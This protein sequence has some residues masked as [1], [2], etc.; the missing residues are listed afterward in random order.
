[1]EKEYPSD[2]K[3]HSTR[4]CWLAYLLTLNLYMC[5]V[6]MC[7]LQT[8]YGF[9]SID[10]GILYPHVSICD[11]EIHNKQYVNVI[12][13]LVGYVG[14]EE[15]C[16]TSK[17]NT[18]SMTSRVER[19]YPSDGKSSGI[20]PDVYDNYS[21]A[22]VPYDL[23]YNHVYIPVECVYLLSNTM[24]DV[25]T[26]FVLLQVEV[27][28]LVTNRAGSGRWDDAATGRVQSVCMDAAN[29][30]YNVV[31]DRYDVSPLHVILSLPLPCIIPPLH[32]AE[33]LGYK[34][35]PYRHIVYMLLVIDRVLYFC[36]IQ[37]QCV[38]GFNLFKP[39]V[40][41]RAIT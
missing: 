22:A 33:S 28:P 30:S 24:H 31:Y 8:W 26:I 41:I 37:T 3:Q 7:I 21:S 12:L 32:V 4:S 6:S 2:C 19:E 15:S 25:Y 1:M 38:C 11:D 13:T 18:L 5:F 17:C 23:L 10:R 36:I 35:K 39:F 40:R 34:S 27:C 14:G 20:V 16:N 29:S 9:P